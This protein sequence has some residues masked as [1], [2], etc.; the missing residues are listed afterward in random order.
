M[1]G[2]FMKNLRLLSLLVGISLYSACCWAAAEPHFSI[3]VQVANQ[4]HTGYVSQGAA[5]S[6]HQEKQD[7]Y[8]GTHRDDE[9]RF[10][11]WRFHKYDDRGI[12]GTMVRLSEQEAIIALEGEAAQQVPIIRLFDK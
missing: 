9:N 11:F 1:I 6:F 2:N 7:L 8:L 3:D 5:W 4:A 10:S 12:H